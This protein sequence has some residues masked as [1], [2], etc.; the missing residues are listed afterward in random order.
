MLHVAHKP[1]FTFLI[2]GLMSLAAPALAHS[3]VA[4]TSPALAQQEA[5]FAFGALIDAASSVASPAE[6]HQLQPFLL[7]YRPDAQLDALYP[8]RRQVAESV[9]RWP[10]SLR[11]RALTYLL[12]HRAAVTNFNAMILQVVGGAP[13]FLSHDSSVPGGAPEQAIYAHRQVLAGLLRDIWSSGQLSILW[14]QQQLGWEAAQLPASTLPRL[15]RAIEA[16]TRSQMPALVAGSQIMVDPLMPQGSGVTTLFTGGRFIMLIGPTLQIRDQNMLVT[17]ELLHPLVNATI[18]GNLSLQMALE[19]DQCS[20]ERIVQDA[21]NNVLTQYVYTT[22]ESYLSEV[23]VRSISHRLAGVAE[24]SRDPFVIAADV[25]A[26]LNTFER[27]SGSLADA[28]R[29]LSNDLA[30][31]LCRGNLHV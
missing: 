15:S 18:H 7:T 2:V 20:F 27:S 14:N 26:H 9:Q 29:R 1:S 24:P 5:L 10:L 11:R 6:L 17:H 23:M 25:A 22:W 19:A 4:A 28:T 30:Q 8:V 13:L 3:A 21:P 12:G 16:Y 31:H